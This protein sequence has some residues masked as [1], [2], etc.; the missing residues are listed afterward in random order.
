MIPIK[1]SIPHRETPFVNYFLIGIN[2]LIFFYEASLPRAELEL[3]IHHYG[4]IPAR[5][6]HPVWAMFVGLSPNNYLPFLTDMFLHG[7]WFH[8]I[9][10]MWS[11]YIFG[12][13]VEDRMGHFRYL[14][15]YL[16]C[17][18]GAN[19][20]HFWL[21]ADSTLPTVGASGAIAGVMGAYL[22]L[23][24]LA[25]IVTLIPI[26]IFPFFVEIPAFF[27]LVFWFLLQ[28][29][30]GMFSLVNPYGSA[31]IAFFAHVGG[32]IC[33][34]FMVHLFKNKDYRHLYLDETLNYYK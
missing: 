20:C 29:Y 25:R 8:L 5:Y 12:D 34:M 32:F 24:P 17:G 2:T 11:L 14:I 19:L 7:S 9:F 22:I 30:S 28:F 31:N 6:T 15:F 26:F 18:I 3:L 10:N 33:G 1:D 23:F 21:N 13:N 4:L 16:L 27:L